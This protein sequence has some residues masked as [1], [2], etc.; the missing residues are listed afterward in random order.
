MPSVGQL[1]EVV[2]KNR[3]EVD[4]LYEVAIPGSTV[5]VGD[6]DEVHVGDIVEARIS[7]SN[8][9]GLEA[10]VNS[11]RGFIPASQIDRFRVEKFGDYVNQKMQCLVTEVNPKKQKLILSRRAILERELAEQRKERLNAI[12]VGDCLNGTITKVIQ[13][14]AFADIGGLDGFIHVSKL[15][16]DRVTDPTEVVAAGD[17]VQVQVEQVNRNSGKISLSIRATVEH[18]WTNITARYRPDDV[19]QGTVT[20]LADFG[21]FVKLE[22]GVEGLVHVSEIAHHRVVKI[23]NHLNCGDR[24]DVKI[25]SVDP[26]NQKLSL[27]IKATQAPPVK[28]EKVHL[29]EPEETVRKPAIPQSNVPLRGGTD[30]KTGG[31]E[32]GLKW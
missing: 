22:P 2:I 24:V 13:S 29:D 12:Q 28:P 6:W 25:L 18:P 27:S 30:R 31:E 16:W 5:T 3:N 8:T 20:K 11:L 1:I 26:E 10:I 17:Q 7:G 23:S 32:F 15:S 19:V 21:A 4:G 9:G 14:G